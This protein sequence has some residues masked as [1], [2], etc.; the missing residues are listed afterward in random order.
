MSTDRHRRL[1]ND[2]LHRLIEPHELVVMLDDLNQR[3]HQTV[4]H[5]LDLAAASHV[6]AVKHRIGIELEE[7]VLELGSV[8]FALGLGDGGR[9]LG[10]QTAD[11][12]LVLGPHRL[13]RA[14]MP[15]LGFGELLLSA[16]VLL[17]LV[18]HGV[19]FDRLRLS[20]GLHL[21]RNDEAEW[22]ERL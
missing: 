9:A 2:E 7:L 3:P 6:E 18:G 21:Q 11:G 13:H 10:A 14:P 12:P 19:A 17:A 4:P 8:P 5:G 16:Q 15:L 22:P 20:L 1:V